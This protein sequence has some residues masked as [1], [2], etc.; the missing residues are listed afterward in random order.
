MSSG[1]LDASFGHSPLSQPAHPKPR[2]LAVPMQTQVPIPPPLPMSQPFVP[3]SQLYPQPP[4]QQPPSPYQQPQYTQPAYPQPPFQQPAYLQPAYPQQPPYQQPVYPQPPTYQPPAYPQP[5]VT[6]QPAAPPPAPVWKEPAP[7]PNAPPRPQSKA[8]APHPT[9][10]PTP[11]PVP[12]PVPVPPKD[13]SVVDPKAKPAE[14]NQESQE[15]KTWRELLSDALKRR[16]FVTTLISTVVHMVLIIVLALVTIAAKKNNVISLTSSADIA[17]PAPDLIKSAAPSDV[18]MVAAGPKVQAVT[19]P[20]TI[21]KAPK[22]LG[23]VA[24]PRTVASLDNMVIGDA[25]K[26]GG[27]GGL[28]AVS[29]FGS[30]S[31]AKKVVFV[32]DNSQ[33]MDGPR[34]TRCKEEV[35][36][37]VSNLSPQQEFYVIF[38][39]D[40]DYPMLGANAPSKLVTLDAKL[41]DAFFAWVNRLDLYGDTM[42]ESALKRAYALKPDLIYLMTDGEFFD[43]TVEF[44]MKMRYSKIRVNT[45]GFQTSD[46]G[47]ESLKKIAETLKGEYTEVN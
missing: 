2:P 12:K 27:A 19:A 40:R 32:V 36:T 7:Q 35:F 9:P 47:R 11:V 16:E 15:P 17:T 5:P 30:T 39:S 28:D 18:Q 8:R 37:A 41:W 6:Q 3:P 4:Y 1:S 45:I 22:N 44:C 10:R 13:K 25:T 43:N 46:A 38:F 29:F 14:Q 34:W 21:V 24:A 20:A 26:T 42:A 23:A 33:S 31:I